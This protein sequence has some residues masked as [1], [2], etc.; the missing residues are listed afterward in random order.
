M[1][2]RPLRDGD[3]AVCRA[4]H[5]AILLEGF[6]FLLDYDDPGMSWSMYTER[7]SA[8]GRGVGVRPDRVASSFLVGVDALDQILGRVSIRYRLNAF[9]AREGGHIGYAVLPEFRRRGVATE[10][11]RQG[12][13]WLRSRGIDRILVVCNDDNV[14]SATVIERAGGVF[15]SVVAGDGGPV[16][17][18]W[19]E[20]EPPPYAHRQPFRVVLIDAGATLALRQEVLRPHQEAAALALPDD[21]A[22]T[23]ASF[24]ALDRRGAVISCARVALARPPDVVALPLVEGHSWQLRGMATAVAWR[25]DG[26]G[27]EVLATVLSHTRAQGPGLV[28]CN[29]RLPARSLYRRAGFVEFGEPWVDPEIGPHVVMARPL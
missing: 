2:L 9:L 8:L 1:T 11:L 10:L 17:R 7:L 6:P 24:A 20:D 12:V 15:D 16:R 3:E 23:T 22:A 19:I 4:A 13:E 18:Y 25:G 21:A 28:W 29:A 5:E 27:S 14:G 26:V